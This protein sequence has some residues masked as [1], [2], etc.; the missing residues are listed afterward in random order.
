MTAERL[1]EEAKDACIKNEII[2]NSRQGEGFVSGY[3]CAM[4][5]KES[6]KILNAQIKSTRLGKC[7]GPAFTLYLT[8]D[9][10]DGGG[11]SVGGIALD[12]YDKKK[13]ERVGSAYGMNVI[14]RVLKVVGVTKWEELTGKF[15]RIECGR[16][17]STVTKFGNLMKDDWMDFTTFGKEWL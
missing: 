4:I 9:I 3:M 11:V 12:E 13:E 14:M 15:I 2:L 17:G 5:Q 16:I 10:Q 7:D 8:L 1:Q 6:H